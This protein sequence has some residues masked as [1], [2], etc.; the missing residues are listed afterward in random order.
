MGCFP[1][2]FP[3]PCTVFLGITND[4][5]KEVEP[6]NGT[7]HSNKMIENLKKAKRSWYHNIQ[8]ISFLLSYSQQS[9]N[10]K[11][12]LKLSSRRQLHDQL[13]L[14]AWEKQKKATARE[15][16]T[17]PKSGVVLWPQLTS[18][19][20]IVSSSACFYFSGIAGKRYYTRT[21]C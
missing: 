16:L 17:Q 5:A 13:R 4:T 1:F 20:H 14:A 19:Y 10:K 9:W 3:K 8:Q 2:L 21:A 11:A 12:V 7:F 6:G 18:L 15:V